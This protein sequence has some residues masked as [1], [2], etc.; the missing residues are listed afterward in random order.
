MNKNKSNINLPPEWVR[1]DA[2]M[3]AW[4]HSDTDWG[5][6]LDEA[7]VCYVEIAKH[8]V[9]QENLI[10]VT[11]HVEAAQSDLKEIDI[12]KHSIKYYQVP[13]ND[14]WARDFGAITVEENG[15]LTP[16]DF[17]FNAWGMKFAAHKDNLVNDTLARHGIFNQPLQNHCGFVLE[18]GSIE[19][20]GNGTIMTTTSCLLSKNRNGQMSKEEIEAYLKTTF[21][22]SKVLWLNHGNMPGDDTDGHIDTIARFA[23][24]NTIVYSGI[25]NLK[26]KNN[27]HAQELD[28][29]AQELQTFTNAQGQPYNLIELPTPE[30]IHDK[31][32]NRLPA[33]YAN[34]LVMNEQVL[35]P[36]YGQVM[37][38]DLALK[39]MQVAFP[40]RT[41]AG[42]DCNALIKQHGSLHCV[43]MQFPQ[44]TLKK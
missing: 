17:M 43:T 23:P 25:S 32:G 13:T 10:I 7:V 39:I 14:T 3:L 33:T 4:P 1:Q 44:N 31:E 2:V 26:E 19:S 29:M 34:F 20:D 40:D 22:A 5:N 8:I 27:D 18:G 9:K 15:R 37:N 16:L 30:P 11:P 6:M 36:T 42:I 24:D 41:I 38:D 35:V 28:G 21:G 12:T